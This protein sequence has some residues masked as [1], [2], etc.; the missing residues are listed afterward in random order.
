MTWISKPEKQSMSSLGGEKSKSFAAYTPSE[1]RAAAGEW[2]RNFKDHGPLKIS[3]I[4]VSEERD[5]FVA[6]VAYSE[7]TVETT[8]QYFADYRPMRRSA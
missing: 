2:L 8:P 5:L 1:A 6:T 4:R 3:S 7:M